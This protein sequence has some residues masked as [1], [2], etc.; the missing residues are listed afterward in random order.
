MTSP[1]KQTNKTNTSIIVN[2]HLMTILHTATLYRVKHIMKATLAIPSSIP[3]QTCILQLLKPSVYRTNVQ[4][5]KKMCPSVTERYLDVYR[6][7]T[8]QF[9]VVLGCKEQKTI[10][11]FN[12]S[13]IFSLHF[14]RFE[15]NSE[16]HFVSNPAIYRKKK[17]KSELQWQQGPLKAL[18]DKVLLQTCS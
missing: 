4:T 18:Q 14:F 12:I 1:L 5:Q 6:K 9:T 3:K 16:I 15:I 8:K 10:K 13:L 2:I 11:Y 7:T 17:K